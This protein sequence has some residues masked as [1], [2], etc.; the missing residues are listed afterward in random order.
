MDEDRSIF[1]LSLDLESEFI[2]RII[3]PAKPE[4]IPRYLIYNQIR[5]S[6]WRR[7]SPKTVKDIECV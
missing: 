7:R 4:D 3:I 1:I 6:V 2:I 5:R